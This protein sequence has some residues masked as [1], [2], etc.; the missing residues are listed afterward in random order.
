MEDIVG[1]VTHHTV[2]AFVLSIS[3]AQSLV[4]LVPVTPRIPATTEAA[5]SPVAFVRVADEG[6]PSAPPDT[7]FPLAVPVKAAVTV[8]KEGLE[9]VVRAWF[10]AVRFA[11][12]ACV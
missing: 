3:V 11:L 4:I 1:I 2:G 6:V 12:Y 10:I 7:R 9:V 5:G 8:V